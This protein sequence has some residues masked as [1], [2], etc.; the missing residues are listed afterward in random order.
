M[1]GRLCEQRGS[2]RGPDGSERDEGHGGRFR[3]RSLPVSPFPRVRRGGP[4]ESVLPEMS[5]ANTVGRD[6]PYPCLN[7][8]KTEGPEDTN[9]KEIRRKKGDPVPYHQ[10]QHPW[11]RL[12]PTPP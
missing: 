4:E 2:R 11:T 1:R 5:E 7:P 6:H 10:Y 12:D 3:S 8:W 9:S